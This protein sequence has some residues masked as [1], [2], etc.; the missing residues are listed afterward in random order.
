MN[1]GEEWGGGAVSCLMQP[2]GTLFVITATTR[3]VWC[4]TLT[5]TRRAIVVIG[6]GG[7]FLL[8]QVHDVC[9]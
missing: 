8:G 1:V 4:G 5:S 2:N 7:G 6:I 3:N 9:M